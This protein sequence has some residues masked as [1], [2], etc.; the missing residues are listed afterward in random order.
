MIQHINDRTENF[1]DSLPWK[2]NKYK[3]HVKQ[4]LNLFIGQCNE[5]WN[6]KFT[7]IQHH[8]YF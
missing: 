5:K 8:N 3:K 2:K 6:L 4:E 7:A 1:D